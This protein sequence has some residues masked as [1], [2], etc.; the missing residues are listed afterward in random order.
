[1]IF[2]KQDGKLICAIEDNGPGINATADSLN[3]NGKSFGMLIS[4]NRA[5]TYNDI[6]KANIEINATDKKDQD[7]GNE[8]TLITIKMDINEAKT[9]SNN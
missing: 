4:S 7:P 5:K 9:H 1:V 8:G 3:G 2:S 6:F